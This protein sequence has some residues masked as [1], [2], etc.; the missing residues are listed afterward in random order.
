MVVTKSAA[1]LLIG[2]GV[3]AWCG[4]PRNDHDFTIIEGRVYSMTGVPVG[5]ARVSLSARSS[6]G[7]DDEI[8]D[9]DGCFHLHAR[10]SV[11]DRRAA[12]NVEHDS[13]AGWERVVRDT[14]MMTAVV[15][16][17]TLR[18]RSRG[19]GWLRPRELQDTAFPPCREKPRGELTYQRR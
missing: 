4:R 19:G 9:A 17:D 16:L 12:L 13:F 8:T 10:H 3:F 2:L 18:A 15:R 7:R 1:G 14:I 6:G 5:G 11:R